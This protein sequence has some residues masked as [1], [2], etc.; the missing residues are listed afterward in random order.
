MKRVLCCAFLFSLATFGC[1][2]NAQLGKELSSF[3]ELVKEGKTRHPKDRAAWSRY[4][5]ERS[6]S[7]M[8]SKELVETMRSLAVAEP[9]ARPT[10][11]AKA[12]K[13]GGLSD[14]ECPELLDLYQ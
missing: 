3:C 14:F 8:S 12:G 4:V 7:A 10:V 5:A 9:N 11:L 2:E 1:T 6:D 13:R